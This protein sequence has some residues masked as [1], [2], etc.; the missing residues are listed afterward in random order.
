MN[1]SNKDGQSTSTRR[2]KSASSFCEDGGWR[3][4]DGQAVQRHPPSSILDLRSSKTA[5]SFPPRCTSGSVV[6]GSAIERRAA[7]T[8]AAARHPLSHFGRGGRGVREN[9]DWQ[10]N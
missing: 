5:G 6:M 7:L 2:R 9:G 4:E 10:N 3:M 8:P 1:L